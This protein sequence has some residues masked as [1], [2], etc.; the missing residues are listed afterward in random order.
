MAVRKIGLLIALAL[1]VAARGDEAAILAALREFFAT[2]D[3]AHRVEIAGRIEQDAAYD[4]V[5]VHEW[6]HQTDLFKPL[7]PGRMELQV[8]LHAGGTRTVVLRIPKD[9][10]P[11][12]PWPLI[13]AL[14]G[15][16]GHA[17]DIIG[18]VQ[19]LLGDEVEHYVIAAPDRYEDAAIHQNEWPPTGEHPAALLKIRQTVHVDSDRVFVLGYSRGGHTS[20]T[21]AIL[22]ADQFAGA[23]PL[24]GSFTMI[25]PDR[26]WETF[27]PNVA[28]LPVLC[29]WGA[30]D[31]LGNDRR[32]SPDGGIAGM[33]RRLRELGRKLE[34]PMTMIEL[35]DKGHRDVVPPSDELAKILAQTRVAYPRQV[36]HTFRHLC[37]GSAYWLEAHRWVGEQWTDKKRTIV[38]REGDPAAL[39]LDESAAREYR[40]L[41]AE[42][43]G[44]IDGQEIRVHRKKISELTVWIGD[45]MIDWDQPVVLNTGDKEPFEVKLQPDLYVCLS[46]AAR[47]WDFDRVRWA[48]IRVRPSAGQPHVV[49]PK[50]SFPAVFERAKPKK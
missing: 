23:I 11:A 1:G 43:S 19:H 21:L 13:Y 22:Y 42:L 46:Q 25:V 39:D 37:Q 36:R 26:L 7:R 4:R 14:H 35:P 16:N 50:T 45:G 29:V 24:A 33:N 41:L 32:E 44:E 17:A 30:D 10:D 12:R 34:L 3:V 5:R 28:N 48:G 38:L 9:Y 6:L 47:T 15:M 18:Y 27:L 2:E 49:T 8:P 40:G 31:T 20:W